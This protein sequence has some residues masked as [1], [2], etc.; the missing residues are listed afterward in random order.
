M[1]TAKLYGQPVNQWYYSA[2]R[3]IFGPLIECFFRESTA[4]EIFNKRT[5]IRWE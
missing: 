1:Q 4:A 3:N 5:S 2:R